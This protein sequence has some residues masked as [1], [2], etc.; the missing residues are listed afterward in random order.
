MRNV[1]A[2]LNYLK[3]QDELNEPE[4]N[5]LS[6]VPEVPDIGPVDTIISVGDSVIDF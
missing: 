3:K 6:Y 4:A 5:P 2:V 1:Q